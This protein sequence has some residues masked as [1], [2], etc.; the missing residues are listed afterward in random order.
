MPQPLAGIRVIELANFI[1]GP[2]AG[3]LLAD[4]GADVI[5]VEPPKGDMGR[6]M[7]PQTRG[8][9]VSFA[10]LN[11]N[12]RSLVLDLKQ[13][14]AREILLKLAAKS[15]VFL[16]A[17]RPGAL[18]KMGL[19]A[20]D[21]KK[22]NPKIIYTSVS[23]FGQT[24]PYRR[25]AGV[26]LIIEAF[27]GPLS[28]TG[29]PDKMPMRPGVQ[30][31]D[32]FGA[33]FATYATLAGL[34]GAARAGEGRIADVSLVE[35]SIAAAA[36]EAAEYLA[37]GSVPQP[38][39]NRHRLNAPYQLFETRDKRYLAIGTPNDGLFAKLMQVLGLGTHLADPRFA[40]YASR[41]ANEAPLLELVEP[42]VRVREAAE[43][44]AAL[45]EA[46]IP[47]ARVNN[48]KEVFDD[49]HIVARGV[50]GEVDHPR[51]GRMKA[52]RNPVLLD[53]DG[54]TINRYS[55]LL[56][57]HSEEILRELGYAPTAI[58]ELVAAGVTRLAAEKS[59]AAE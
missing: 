7:P 22:A 2:L 24:G 28:V 17:Y 58:A 14:A 51:L 31:A 53:H 48:F 39:G 30:T 59:V 16:E 54:P 25:R 35:A 29:E 20:P 42:A 34:V 8:E 1:A 36:W 9:S 50:V 44:E 11:R 33:L 38:L 56:G 57:E 45:T 23:G 15:D 40:S 46:G 6:A 19:G 13:P 32:V 10:A 37:S 49:P 41:K 21:V 27:A 55:P 3:T 5:K 18:E 52:V 12:K 47:C 26:N 4:M 43:L